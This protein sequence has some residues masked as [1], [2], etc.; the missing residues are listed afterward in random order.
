MIPHLPSNSD[1]QLMKADTGLLTLSKRVTW[2][3]LVFDPLLP[4]SMSTFLSFVPQGSSH[5]SRTQGSGNSNLQPA[6]LTMVNVQWGTWDLLAHSSSQHPRRRFSKGCKLKTNK[7]VFQN[8][9]A[10]APERFCF[11]W[12]FLA[13]LKAS[14]FLRKRQ[15]LPGP[16]SRGFRLPESTVCWQCTDIPSSQCCSVEPRLI[17]WEIAIHTSQSQRR[18]FGSSYTPSGY[19]NCC[20]VV[21]T[22]SLWR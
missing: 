11:V 19:S 6:P 13:L 17:F 15:V 21:S 4:T 22:W 14:L 8:S 1:F 5:S 2:M 3:G 18:S 9:S 12:A 20:H 16:P 7:W 10:A